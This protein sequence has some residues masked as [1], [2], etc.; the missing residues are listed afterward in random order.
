MSDSVG[1]VGA[2]S[3]NSARP[4]SIKDCKPGSLGLK[5]STVHRPAVADRLTAVREVIGTFLSS[6]SRTT[7]LAAVLPSAI[8]PP[9]PFCAN[10]INNLAKAPG[11]TTLMAF[12]PRSL[13]NESNCFTDNV[14]SPAIRLTPR[15]SQACDCFSASVAFLPIRSPAI[16]LPLT[17]SLNVVPAVPLTRIVVCANP[18]ICPSLMPINPRELSS[19]GNNDSSRISGSLALRSIICFDVAS[20]C[21]R[22]RESNRSWGAAT[23]LTKAELSIAAP[24][25]AGAAIL[26]VGASVPTTPDAGSALMSLNARKF[27]SVSNLFCKRS[28][29]SCFRLA[30]TCRRWLISANTSTVQELIAKFALCSSP[31]FKSTI[32]LSPLPKLRLDRPVKSFT[33]TPLGRVVRSIFS[34]CVRG[35]NP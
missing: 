15:N 10:S 7:T 13:P 5:S 17:Y 2:I 20:D 30:A 26:A 3:S 16:S 25:A 12:S 8:A 31:C 4:P 1:S 28:S 18:R 24:S 19:C 14:F 11:A 35:S 27:G 6:V 21:W 22:N 23:A 33:A 32:R 9:L 29:N 34:T